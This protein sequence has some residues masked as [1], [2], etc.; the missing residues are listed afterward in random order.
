MRGGRVAAALVALAVLSACG[1]GADPNEED[2]APPTVGLLRLVPD[3]D[4]GAF[5]DELR[6][7]GWRV[8]EDVELVPTDPGELYADVEEAGAAVQSWLR[9]D[10]DL[11]V[12][13]STPFAQL[14]SGLDARVPGLFVVNDPVA[15][16]LVGDVLQP[17]GVMTGVTFRTPADRMLALASEALGG[18]TRAGYLYPSDDPAVPGHRDAF[19]AAAAD[20][21]IEVVERAFADPSEVAAAVAEIAGAGVQVVAVPSTNATVRALDELRSAIDEHG[22][23]LIGNTD[24]LDFAVLVLTPDGAELRRQLARQVVRILEGA[25]VSNVPVEDPRKFT[26]IVD[27]SKVRELGLPPVP[28]GVLRQADVVR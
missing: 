21:G 27:R 7:Q 4:H 23:P 13:F 10:L 1:G 18:V 19:L 14:V 8:G 3:E 6:R 24:L 2:P 5:V 16:G 28:E 12:A 17:D 15:A 20:L 11:I 25:D 9:D 22:L 26:L